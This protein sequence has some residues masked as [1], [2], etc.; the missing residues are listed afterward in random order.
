VLCELPFEESA[1]LQKDLQDQI[2]QLHHFRAPPMII[3]S[4]EWRLV[5]ARKPTAENIEKAS[6]E[7]LRSLLSRW[8]AEA[9]T[10][11]LDKGW[12]LLYWFSDPGRR[13]RV[14][15]DLR[16]QEEGFSL[17]T[18]DYALNGAGPYP[19]AA[20]GQPVIQT[21]GNL[22]DSLY[23]PPPLVQTIAAALA[24][25]PTA[26]WD[27]L[28]AEIET[29]SEEMRPFGAGIEERLEYAREMFEQFFRFYWRAADRGFGVS[30]EY[31]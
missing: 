7:E 29:R 16:A 1:E 31:Y 8:S 24:N 18:L 26:D 3:E 4:V 9:R 14:C 25:V 22:D 6:L 27:E 15:G 28:D 12:D 20:D 11:D 13:M 10:L 21:G 2:A 17:S 23:N 5:R 30:V 19:L